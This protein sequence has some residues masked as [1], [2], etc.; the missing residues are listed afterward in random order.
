MSA[1]EVPSPSLHLIPIDIATLRGLPRDLTFNIFLKLSDNNSP[2]IFSTTG[3]LDYK[4]LAHYAK[5]G[6]K[7]L[8]IRVED[9]DLY[10]LF[11]SKS[12]QSVFKDPDSSRERQIASLINITEQNITEIFEYFDVSEETAQVTQKLIRN[13]V[14]V[15][16]QSPSTLSLLLQLVSHGDYLYYHSIAVSI[17]SMFVAKG[18]G[19]FNQRTLEIVGLG[20]FLHDIGSIQL[21]KGIVCSPD[22][23]TEDQWKEMRTHPQIGLKMVENAPSIPDEVRYIIYQ[24]HEEPSGY[25]YP[26]GIRSPVIYYPAKIVALADAFS[27]LISKRP[28]RPAYSVE[29]AGE[30]IRNSQGKYDRALLKVFETVFVRQIK[31]SA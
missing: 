20:G 29:K 7:Q 24:H 31:K 22:A 15:M 8:H 18:C 14:D 26:N 30:I 27:A 23:L 4:R 16:I 6:I 28:S 11:V 17:F 13:Y 9:L 1:K 12:A 25:G 2:C 10:R 21:P 3:G 19:Q 5:K